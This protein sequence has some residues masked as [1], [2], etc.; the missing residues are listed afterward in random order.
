M[1]V[2]RNFGSFYAIQ[3][4]NGSGDSSA[5]VMYGAPVRQQN[6]HFAVLVVTQ[7]PTPLDS[8]TFSPLQ[9][10]SLHILWQRA[11]QPRLD[12]VHSER[13]HTNHCVKLWLHVK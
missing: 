2:K 12:S 13:I 7:C 6:I 5:R 4:G 10:V 1:K 9:A 3:P 11:F 8:S